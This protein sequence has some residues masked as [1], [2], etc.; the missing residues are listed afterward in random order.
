MATAVLP[1]R[2]RSF[3]GGDRADGGDGS[4][5]VGCIGAAR[6]VLAACAAAS[7]LVLSL[8]TAAENWYVRNAEGEASA[9][10]VGAMDGS[11]S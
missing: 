11:T 3:C 7:S 2:G 4:V 1:V 5:Y 10:A 9:S 8:L 6:Q